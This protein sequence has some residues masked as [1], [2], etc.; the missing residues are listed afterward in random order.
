[1]NKD[2]NYPSPLADRTLSGQEYTGETVRSLADLSSLGIPQNETELRQRINDFFSFCAEHNLR[3]GIESLSL[4]LGVS[5]VSFWQWCRSDSNK[6]HEWVELCRTA[7]QLI[8]SFTEQAA[9]SGHIS[10]P[11]GI[12][13]L[14]NLASYRDTISFEDISSDDA[15]MTSETSYEIAKKMGLILSDNIEK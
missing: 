14:K 3:P 4:A 10:P 12:F 7:K 2:S 13:L 1:M 11:V 15:E 6:S 9:I 5:R 8:I